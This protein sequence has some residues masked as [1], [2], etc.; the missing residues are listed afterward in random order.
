MKNIDHYKPGSFCWVELGTTDQNAAKKFYGSLFGWEAHDLPMGPSGSYTFFKLHGRD[1]GAGY[2]LNQEMLDHHVPPH[3][4]IYI[5]VDD[6]DAKAVDVKSAGGTVQ[7]GPFDVFDV[8]RM[9]VCHDPTGAYFCI[10]Q[11]KEGVANGIA[12]VDGSFCWADLNTPD[13]ATAAKFYNQ[14]FGWQISEDKDGYSHIKNGD[15]NIGGIPSVRP[16]NPRVPAHWMAYFLTSDCKGLAAKAK[17]LGARAMLEPMLM[18]N[19]GTIA[20]LADP[21]GAVFAL[22]QSVRK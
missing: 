19:V 4:M 22:Y 3:W 17:Q 12:E 13:P 8:G 15:T 21:Q 6:A 20:I 7:K 11:S 10:W 5:A 2:T 18:E 9:A 1:A 16:N 14:V